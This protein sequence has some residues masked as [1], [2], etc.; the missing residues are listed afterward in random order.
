MDVDT[1]LTLVLVIQ[2]VLLW[3]HVGPLLPAGVVY[4]LVVL[5]FPVVLLFGVWKLARSQSALQ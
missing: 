5:A 2:A 1:K 3:F 4:H